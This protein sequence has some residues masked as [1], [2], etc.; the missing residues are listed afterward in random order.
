MTEIGDT[1]WKVG[2]VV[3]VGW[4]GED[5]SRVLAVVVDAHPKSVLVRHCANGELRLVFRASRLHRPTAQ[6][7]LEG[8]WPE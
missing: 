5:E 6:E 7:L 3:A 2:D 1:A 8:A 4:W